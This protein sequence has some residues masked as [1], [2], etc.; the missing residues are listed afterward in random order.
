MPLNTRISK[1]S[2]SVNTEYWTQRQAAKTVFWLP[3]KISLCRLC[4][5][6]QHM[7]MTDF[8]PYGGLPA[9]DGEA[10]DEGV[11]VEVA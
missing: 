2:C 8:G 9:D 3:A 7:R 1:Y 5:Y 10:D 6:A 4:G 11:V